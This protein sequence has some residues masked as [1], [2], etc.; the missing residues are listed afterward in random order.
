M[1]GLVIKGKS[2]KTTPILRTQ[3]VSTKEGM[4]NKRIQFILL[5]FKDKLLNQNGYLA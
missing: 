1:K 5:S 3:V 4:L 2:A